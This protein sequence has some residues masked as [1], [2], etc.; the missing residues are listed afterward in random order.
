VKLQVYD[1][2]HENATKNAS[3]PSCEAVLSTVSGEF[4]QSLGDLAHQE[5]CLGIFFGRFRLW[6]KLACHQ[7]RIAPK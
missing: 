2:D 6:S 1:S 3:R 4:D 5:R 7:K